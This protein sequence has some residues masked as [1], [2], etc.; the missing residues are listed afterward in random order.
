MAPE[1]IVTATVKF[2]IW[3]GPFELRLDWTGSGTEVNESKTAGKCCVVYGNK[4]K[5]HK[6]GIKWY[7]Q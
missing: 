7:V 1:I 6:L 3:I 2:W 5:S 4:I